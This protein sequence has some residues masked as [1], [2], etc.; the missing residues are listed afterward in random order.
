MLVLSR[1]PESP[2]STIEVRV[3]GKSVSQWQVPIRQPGKPPAP[4]LVSLEPW[5]GRQV[6]L[7]LVQTS[8]DAEALVE[9]EL[10]EMAGLPR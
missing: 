6:Q 5:R 3:D 10:A 4:L 7:E 1:P 2:P 8:Q 9:W